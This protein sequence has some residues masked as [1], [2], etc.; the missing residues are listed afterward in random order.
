MATAPA[1]CPRCG[2]KFWWKPPAFLKPEE[3]VSAAMAPPI[4]TQLTLQEEDRTCTDSAPQAS[5]KS[6]VS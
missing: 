5:N 3:K 2:S 6:E 4:G 1:R